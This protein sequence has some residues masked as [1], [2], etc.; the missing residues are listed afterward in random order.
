MA[1][2]SFSDKQI[3]FLYFLFLIV[4]GTLL[5]LLPS[6]FSGEGGLR[7]LDAL[8]TTVSAVCVTGL[9]TVSTQDFS[10]SGDRLIHDDIKSGNPVC[11]NHQ[12]GISQVVNIPDLSA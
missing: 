7:V 10:F 9:A 3:L 2:P 11:G 12:E 5:L 4:L 6:S 8:F 1:G